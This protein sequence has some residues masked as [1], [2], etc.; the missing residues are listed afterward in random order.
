M[1][2]PGL[3]NRE[4]TPAPPVFTGPAKV[5]R[6]PPHSARRDRAMRVATARDQGTR[7]AIVAVVADAL[8]ARPYDQVTYTFIAA[9]AQ[10]TAADVQRCFATKAEMV[11][12]ALHPTPAWS[13][14]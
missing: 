4:R 9:L 6:T 13:P 3:L 14:A 8:Q 12:S 11:L 2:I 1:S 5:R 7:D 10:V